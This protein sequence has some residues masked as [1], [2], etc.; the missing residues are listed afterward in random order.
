[1][2]C[3]QTGKQYTVKVKALS[4]EDGEALRE[5]NFVKGASLMLEHKGK[6]YPV[7]FVSYAGKSACV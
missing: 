3:A 1:M 5:S 7:R 2:K 6:S 4:R